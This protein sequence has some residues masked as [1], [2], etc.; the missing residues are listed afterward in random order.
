M[1]NIFV[2]V[3]MFV[4]RPSAK[5]IEIWMQKRAEE[6]PLFGFWEL[7]GGKIEANETPKDAAKREV[8]E[9]T[10]VDIALLPLLFF[11]KYSYEFNERKIHLHLFVSEFEKMHSVIHEGEWF[12]VD[13]AVQSQKFKGKIPPIN[14]QVID[15]VITYL[16]RQFNAGTWNMIGIA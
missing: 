1:K 16:E 11:N 2:S 6:G 10:G 13:Y 14:H 3:V 4:R 12:A 15:E 7:P 8:L 5:G 9:E